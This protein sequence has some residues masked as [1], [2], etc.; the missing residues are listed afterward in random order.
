[1]RKAIALKKTDNELSKMLDGIF[2]SKQRFQQKMMFLKKQG[3][4]AHKEFH[5]EQDPL[6]EELKERL[7]ALNLLPADY[8]DGDTLSYDKEGEVLYWIREEQS[9]D[10]LHK[11]ISQFFG[12]DP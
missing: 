4:Q 10:S 12:Y 1:M 11:F 8:R 6:W 2:E 3:E 9:G 5:N 7:T